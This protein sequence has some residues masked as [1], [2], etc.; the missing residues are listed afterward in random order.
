MLN[1]PLAP[2]RAALVA[3]RAARVTHC[4]AGMLIVAQVC[5]PM[6]PRRP[7][8][9][10]VMSV[11]FLGTAE[12]SSGVLG[13]GQRSLKAGHSVSGRKVSGT[14]RAADSLKWITK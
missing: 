5:R 14:L 3:K 7:D 4:G 10:R 12:V 2:Y 13:D 6:A 8:E 11:L 1:E 9:V